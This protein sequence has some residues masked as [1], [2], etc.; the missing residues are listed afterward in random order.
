[1]KD[2][3]IPNDQIIPYDPEQ[4]RLLD[5]FAGLAMQAWTASMG[6]TTSPE[7]RAQLSYE[8]AQAMIAERERLMRQ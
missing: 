7:R 2:R 8:A 4:Q 3:I 6:A 1:M 5:H